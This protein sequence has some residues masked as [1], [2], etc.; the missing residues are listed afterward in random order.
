MNS[1]GGS[2]E[3]RVFF[4]AQILTTV[5]NEWWAR[6]IFVKFNE[7][8]VRP[9]R[10]ISK[11]AR[12]MGKRRKSVHIKNIVQEG[13]GGVNMLVQSKQMSIDICQHGHPCHYTDPLPKSLLSYLLFHLDLEKVFKTEA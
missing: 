2:R 11:K 4:A 3:E 1:N 8:H 6:N 10:S 7:I 9:W 5:S 12:T 13:G